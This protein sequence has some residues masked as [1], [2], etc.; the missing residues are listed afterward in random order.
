MKII[1]ES[2]SRMVLKD[3][4]YSMFAGGAVFLFIG[5]GVAY[6]LSSQGMVPLAFGVIFAL[7]GLFIILNTRMVTAVL[8]KGHGRLSI[9]MRSVLKGESREEEIGKV[10][11]VVLQK[12]VEVSHSSRRSSGGT[13]YRY[14]LKFLL[15]G[16]SELSLDFGRVGMGSG[17]MSII[18]GLAA[19]PDE[20]KHRDAKQVADFL[21]VP[22]KEMGPPPVSDV[23]SAIKEGIAEGMERAAKAKKGGA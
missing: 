18:G 2:E 8:D 6:F 10:R 17:T 3:H 12:D 14:T 23:L 13:Y 9:S 11:G 19:S 20:R 7:V 1:Q 15:E 5:V 4:R 21:G 16:G 22:L